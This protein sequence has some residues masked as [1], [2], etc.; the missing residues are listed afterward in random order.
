MSE[1]WTT[2]VKETS[3]SIFDSYSYITLISFVQSQHL[4]WCFI[5]LFSCIVYQPLIATYGNNSE[6][7]S[8][9]F[10][11]TFYY[12]NSFPGGSA[13]KQS[14]WNVG[15]HCLIPRLGKFLWRRHRLCIPV[16]L[17]FAGGSDSKESICNVGDLGYIHGL[18][19][20]PGKGHGSPLQYF[21][22]ENPHGHR[23]LVGYSPWSR[24]DSDMTERVSTAEQRLWMNFVKTG[25]ILLFLYERIFLEFIWW[26][27]HLKLTFGCIYI[28]EW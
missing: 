16:F 18:G 17:G 5:F 15:D 26:E 21:F 13:G 24:K 10:I 19:R 3:I 25:L 4:L 22:L 8:L 6:A 12:I 27:N 1:T 23:S 14:T 2:G 20:S 11:F 9:I 28:T 7:V